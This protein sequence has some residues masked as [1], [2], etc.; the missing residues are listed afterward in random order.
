VRGVVVR[1]VA[2]MVDAHVSDCSSGTHGEAVNCDLLG[3]DRND[4]HIVLMP[5]DD[6]EADECES[7]TAEIIPHFR[8]EAWAM[9]DMK[10]PVDNPVRVTGQL[11]Y[12]NAHAKCTAG[13]HPNPKRRTVWEIHPVYQL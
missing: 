5:P 7:I 3:V 1:V 10:T 8:P 12:D 4:L 13:S 6:P 11:F 2:R 9:L